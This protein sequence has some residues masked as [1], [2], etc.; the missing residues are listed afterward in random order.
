MEKKTKVTLE[1][2]HWRTD[3]VRDHMKF[4]TTGRLPQRKPS[5][6]DTEIP[7]GMDRQRERDYLMRQLQMH[8][9]EMPS[10]FTI[11]YEDGTRRRC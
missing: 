3:Y 5:F 7:E 2:I 10:G 11:R 1:G 8:Y 9:G 4:I 6:W